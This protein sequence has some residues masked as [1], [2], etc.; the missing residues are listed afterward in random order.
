[1]VGANYTYEVDTT[2][3]GW[4]HLGIGALALVTG[5][6]L[7]TGMTWARVVGIA[8]AVISAT[9]N[10]FFIP[11]YP[12]WSLLIIGLNI[13]A[14]WALANAGRDTMMGEAMDSRM[15]AGSYGGES[16]QEGER[17]PSTN[18]AAGR[19]WKAE[20]EK[21]GVRGA[22]AP[23]SSRQAAE[24]MAQPGTQG[25]PM[26]GQPMQGQPMQDPRTPPTAP[27]TGG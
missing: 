21:E 2:A 17:W 26:Q 14:I 18:V 27:P 7:F 5:F 12:L 13:F 8:L 11:Y 19:H 20:P 4:I 22:G 16:M 15:M 9:A 23:E 6:F 3:W 1:V 24:A 10:F 25:Q